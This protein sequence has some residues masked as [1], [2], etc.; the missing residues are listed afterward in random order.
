MIYIDIGM[1][2]IPVSGVI[3]LLAWRPKG[4]VKPMAYWIYQISGVMFVL[5]G[6]LTAFGL[7]YIVT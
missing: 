5:G 3:H 7:G 1:V 4:F 2:L 6:L